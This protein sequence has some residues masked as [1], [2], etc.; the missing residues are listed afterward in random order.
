VRFTKMHG[1]GNDF[2]M[3]DTLLDGLPMG[4]LPELSRE[5][6]DRRLGIGGDGLILVERGDLEPFRMRMFNPDGSESEMC[7]NGIRCFAKLLRDHGHT[8]A[9]EIPVETGA[10]RL[11]LELLGDGQVR[12][13]MGPARLTRGEIPMSGP[14][15]ETFL[16]LPVGDYVGTAVSMGNP[17]LVIFVDDAASVEL[18]E[19]GSKLER[20]PLFPRRTNV[21][22]V[23]VLG[24]GVLLQRTWERGAGITLACG[25]GACASGVA[26]Y[27]TGRAARKAEVRLPGGVLHIEY[28]EDGRVM[29][30]GP[31]ETVFE[32]DWP[33]RG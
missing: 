9:S 16:D 7:G 28:R 8:K 18:A 31:A 23:Q 13:D 4:D 21:H 30:T 2:V 10:G 24:G 6:N 27:L 15:G 1:I 19:E 17:H 14:A 11:V 25:T 29:M 3:V 22:F 12:V 32:G 33:E 26:A 5:V 20:N